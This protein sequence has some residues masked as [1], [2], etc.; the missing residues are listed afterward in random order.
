MCFFAAHAVS[1]SRKLRGSSAS[2]MSSACCRSCAEMRAPLS[3]SATLRVWKSRKT[4]GTFFLAGDP[5]SC[6]GLY[7]RG[8]LSTVL[9]A[10]KSASGG[11]EVTPKVHF[12]LKNLPPFSKKKKNEKLMTRRE[13]KKEKPDTTNSP[14]KS[15]ACPQLKHAETT[16]KNCKF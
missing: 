12:L 10:H 1:R 16:L 4:R 9:E 7:P 13:V 3:F 14:W 2:L 6:A 15:Q 11:T 8:N 5:I